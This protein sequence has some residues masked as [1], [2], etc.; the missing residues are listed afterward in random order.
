[1]DSGPGTGDI[2]SKPPMTTV[3]LTYAWNDNDRGD[4]DFIA[5]DLR[6]AGFHVCLD[7]W[8]PTRDARLWDQL[9]EPFSTAGT[10]QAW[11]LYA[12]PNSLG[13]TL[14]QGD[15][16]H[17]MENV[18]KTRGAQ[19]PVAVLL[20]FDT[21]RELLA[22][23]D[24]AVTAVPMT[25]PD[26]KDTVRTIV[27]GRPPTARAPRVTPFDIKVWRAEREDRVG[28]A[29]EFRPRTGS[30]SPVFAAVPMD[31]LKGIKPQLAH[32]P[33]G[34]IPAV[35]WLDRPG[36]GQLSSGPYW[37]L[38]SHNVATPGESCYLLCDRL[39][40]RMIFGVHKGE[41]QFQVSFDPSTTA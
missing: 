38:W 4:V 34:R 12:T 14:C 8:S 13:S 24:P 1:M 22:T 3:W 7:R 10:L 31:E 6:D 2:I 15:F 36:A 21:M 11:L 23:L 26:W 25:R 28:F 19:F 5:Q 9:R 33:T 29:I 41:P 35:V 30:W 32:G 20:Q 37:A 16:S 18:R 27:E 39:P 40:S 17:A